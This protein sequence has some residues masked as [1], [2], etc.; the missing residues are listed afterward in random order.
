MPAQLLL[1]DIWLRPERTDIPD[2]IGIRLESD[3]NPTELELN[4]GNPS[5]Q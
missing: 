4:P 1:A 5:E 3:W 2:I